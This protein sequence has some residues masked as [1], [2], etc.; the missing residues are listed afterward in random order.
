MD[1]TLSLIS[2]S[3][4]AGK[5]R[6]GLDRVADTVLAGEAQI[7]LLA[8]DLSENSRSKLESKLSRATKPPN[9]QTISHTQQE[10]EPIC[11]RKTGILAITDQGF[12]QGIGKLIDAENKED[13]DI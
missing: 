4:K 1:K 3:R 8:A 13:K 11:G 12:A 5:L 9:I 10:L 6:Y 7:V 2:L